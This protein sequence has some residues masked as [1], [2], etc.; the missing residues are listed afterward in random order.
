MLILLALDAPN[1]DWIPSDTT[2]IFI[3][4]V[5]LGISIAAY[6][7]ISKGGLSKA[8]WSIP[9]ALL[10]DW[11]TW[12]EVFTVLMAI[13]LVIGIVGV[14][15]YKY[16]WPSSISNEVPKCLES[17]A[18]ALA[19][20]LIGYIPGR[21]AASSA[22]GDKEKALNL[23]GEERQYYLDALEKAET[24]LQSLRDELPPNDEESEVG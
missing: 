11:T 16:I 14:I 8:F 23:I 13:G 24:I 4:M 7:S 1:V 17:L 15:C 20:Y 3:G 6:D 5:L 22:E 9:G 21:I 18:S 12:R 2:I 19:G 10:K